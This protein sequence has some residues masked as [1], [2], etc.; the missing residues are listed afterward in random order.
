M[1][2]GRKDQRSAVDDRRPDQNAESQEKEGKDVV[3]VM[4]GSKNP[5]GAANPTG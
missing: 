3:A 2:T 5:I 4:R 1:S